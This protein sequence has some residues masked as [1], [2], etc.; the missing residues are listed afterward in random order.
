MKTNILITYIN[1]NCSLILLR[2]HYNLFF[3]N[4]VVCFAKPGLVYNSI[5]IEKVVN[6]ARFV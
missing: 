1:T 3:K 6:A 2:K 5:S 4:I